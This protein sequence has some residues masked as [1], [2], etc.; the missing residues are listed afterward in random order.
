MNDLTI[1]REN[2][3]LFGGSLTL[4]G[5]GIFLVENYKG[6]IVATLFGKYGNSYSEPGGSID[7]GESPLETACRETR[8]ETANLIRIK[9][10]E[11]QQHSKPI[12]IG[13]YMAYIMYI[14]NIKSR[15]YN[16]N[17]AKIFKDCT[18]HHWK[19]TNSMAR[20]S[21]SVLINAATKNISY[22]TNISGAII[23]IHPRTLNIV[24]QSINYLNMLY[25]NTYPLPLYPNVTMGSRNPCL[26]GTYSCTLTSLIGH[27]LIQPSNTT[28]KNFKIENPSKYAIYI[29]PNLPS[30]FE[31]LHKCNKKWKGI[32]VTLVGFSS[33][34][35]KLKKIIKKI[36]QNSIVEWK[37]DIDTFDIKN[38]TIF[39]QSQTLDNIA[40]KL[41][42]KGI[43]KIK[44]KFFS[45]A[46]WH[47]S[48]VDC[49]I[50]S[51]IKDILKDVTWSFV[52]AEE[53]NDGDYNWIKSYPVHRIF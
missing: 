38:N 35:P 24:R 40:R 30:E 43:Q 47:M 20:V 29:V 8:E 27:P 9:P 21:L 50:P 51:N 6:S 12:N 1:N 5:A 11:L 14:K 52:V 7:H 18:D 37:I 46:D 26:I 16:F 25:Y 48:F 10:Q 45:G 17:V 3:E 19:E 53:D 49:D 44:G 33:N 31:N 34:H 2:T 13:G 15:L 22:V 41:S 4:T 28:I 32:H 39:F 23:N 42:K 36:S